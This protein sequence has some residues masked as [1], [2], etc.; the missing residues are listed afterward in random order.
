MAGERR[1]NFYHHDRD[2]QVITELAVSL[3]KYTT[4]YEEALNYAEFAIERR[5]SWVTPRRIK[6]MA[7]LELGY[8]DAADAIIEEALQ[9]K[10]FSKGYLT[11]GDIMKTRREWVGAEKFYRKAL[12][13]EKDSIEAMMRVAETVVENI[14]G[15]AEGKFHEAELL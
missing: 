15:K 7:L 4:S 8:V 10:N 9:I 11:K 13:M 12:D 1:E 5:P 6:A 2:I 3:Q 14:E